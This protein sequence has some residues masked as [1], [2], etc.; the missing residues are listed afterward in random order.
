MAGDGRTAGAAFHGEVV[1][2]QIDGGDIHLL[3]FDPDRLA[4]GE[5]GGIRHLDHF[6]LGA[7]TVEV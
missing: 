5:F 2:S 6:A 4:G 1:Q 3:G 7:L